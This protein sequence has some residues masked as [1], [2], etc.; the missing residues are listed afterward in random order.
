MQPRP[1][2]LPR[3]LLPACVVPRACS[4]L[5]FLVIA[6]GSTAAS[7]VEPLD[8]SLERRFADDVQPFLKSYCLS[9]HG[10]K[11]QEAKLDLRGF[12]SLPAVVKNYRVWET[13]FERLDAEEMPPAKAQ[14]QPTA[15]E[16]RK[17][18]QWIEA[19]GDDIVRRNAG[20]P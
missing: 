11:R 20:D 7:A 13:V 15:D 3:V 10:E 2:P 8:Q 18:I 16:R 6:L 14:K 5:C 1:S 12:S 9:C 19:V 4:Y 17:V